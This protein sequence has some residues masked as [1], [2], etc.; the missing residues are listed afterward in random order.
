MKKTVF[1]IAMFIM[2]IGC[3]GASHAA[4]E[5]IGTTCTE[6]AWQSCLTNYGV[7]YD[8]SCSN[9]ACSLC[10]NRS[11]SA[12]L[13]NSFGIVTST[14]Y[15]YETN[16]PSSYGG[17]AT[18]SCKQTSSSYKCAS[19]YY[20]T[21]TSSTSGCTACPSN[22]TCAG[23]N[24]STFSCNKGY[25]KDGSSCSACPGIGTSAAGATSISSCYIPAGTTY[26]DSTGGGE[27][28]ANCPY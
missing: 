17:T 1:I 9:S 20:G 27:Y 24:N 21:A 23:G 3:A 16:C 11:S 4:N 5:I 8:S 2:A 25:Y 13:T 6:S 12:G 22:A 28:T 19:G 7:T 14:T 18:C 15:R 26:S 10:N